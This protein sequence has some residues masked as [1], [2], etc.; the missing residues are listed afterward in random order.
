MARFLLLDVDGVLN[1]RHT[2]VHTGQG[3]CF[4][5]DFLVQRVREDANFLRD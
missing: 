2:R 4:A 3:Y 5:D 1:N